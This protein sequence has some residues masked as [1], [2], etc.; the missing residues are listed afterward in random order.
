MI[1]I[2]YYYYCHVIR[3][4][5]RSNSLLTAATY[6]Q[7][8]TAFNFAIDNDQK[9]LFP[10]AKG[11]FRLFISATYHPYVFVSVYI[12]RFIRMLVVCSPILPVCI[13]MLPVCCPCVS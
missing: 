10:T 6:S 7:P 2:L 3:V 8:Y 4:M 9:A 1:N 12:L 13:R 11:R 5:Y